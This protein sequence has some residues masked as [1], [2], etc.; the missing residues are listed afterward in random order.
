MEKFEKDA[1]GVSEVPFQCITMLR[2]SDFTK[3]VLRKLHI[4]KS[5]Q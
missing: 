4:C 3:T 5:L 1:G 2:G